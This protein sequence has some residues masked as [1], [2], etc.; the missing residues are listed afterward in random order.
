MVTPDGAEGVDAVSYRTQDE[1][2]SVNIRTALTKICL[3]VLVIIGSCFFMLPRAQ[4]LLTPSEP[5]DSGVRGLFVVSSQGGG[6]DLELKVHQK[7]DDK[8]GA[9]IVFYFTADGLVYGLNGNAQAIDFQVDFVGNEGGEV[10]CG[11]ANRISEVPFENVAPGPK[12][13]ISVDAN[14]T[15][16]SAISYDSEPRS[17]EEIAEQLSSTIVYEYTGT[18]WPLDSGS[19]RADRQEDDAGN[20]FAE[21]CVFPESS[22]WRTLGGKSF[23]NSETKTLMPFQINWTARGDSI[24][25]QRSLMADIE[26]QR[27]SGVTLTSSYP[28]PAA[29]DSRWS[30]Q[31]ESYWTAGEN[32]ASRFMYSDQPVYLFANR[33]EADRKSILTLWSGVLLG[34]VVTLAV[35]IASMSIDLYEE[36]R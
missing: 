14:S 19:D 8:G 17:A 22:V 28:E 32:E 4:E 9:R 12:R 1:R 30:Y 15:R 25:F 6:R 18:I 26:I 7:F 3:G 34:L 10:Q 13:A 31:Q 23:D 35:R 5:L 11:K 29:Y 24:D 2:G 21:E 16:S 36:F 33:N 20:V 27:E